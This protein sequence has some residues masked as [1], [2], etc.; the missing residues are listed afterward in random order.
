MYVFGGFNGVFFNDILTYTH[1]KIVFL[2]I[3]NTE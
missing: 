2:M 3:Q 1:G